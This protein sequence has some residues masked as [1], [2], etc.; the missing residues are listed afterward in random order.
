VPLFESSGLL[1]QM[2]QNGLV[3]GHLSID[4]LLTREFRLV[5][6]VFVALRVLLLL[7]QTHAIYDRLLSDLVLE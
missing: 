6:K 2:H 5:L 1:L 7:L 4:L 3:G